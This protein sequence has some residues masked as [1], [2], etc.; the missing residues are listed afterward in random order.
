MADELDI[1]KSILQ[2]TTGAVA[3]IGVKTVEAGFATLKKL[4]PD[5]VQVFNDKFKEVTSSIEDDQWLHM[6]SSFKSSGMVSDSNLNNLYKLRKLGHPFDWFFYFM[7]MYGLVRNYLSVTLEGNMAIESQAINKDIRPYLPSY[8]DVINAAF[9]AP[10]KTGEVRD[11]LQRIGFKDEHIDLLFLSRYNLYSEE[12]VKTLYLQGIIDEDR[13]FIRMRELGYTDTRIKE[14]IQSWEVIPGPQDLFWMVGKEAFEPDSIKELG[15]GDEFPEEQLQWLSKQG[16]SEYW[17]KKYWYAHWDQPSIGQGYEMLHRGVINDDQLDMLF[18]TVEMPPFWR[19]KLKQ[20]A[21]QPFTRVDVR[22]MHKLG[23]LSDEELIKAYT[24]LGYEKEKAIKMAQFTIVYNAQVSSGL[25]KT[26]ILSSYKDG[27]LKRTDAKDLLITI[28]IG[29]D[30][31]EFLLYHID[32]KNDQ[33]LIEKQIKNIGDK[34]KLNLI[35]ELEVRRQLGLLNLLSER[36]DVLI[37][38]WTI[39][40]YDD[41]KIPSKTDLDKFFRYGIIDEDTYQQELKRLGYTVQSVQ[42]YLSL[43]KKTMKG[44]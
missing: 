8:S 44:E 29:E 3:P 36:V 19:E 2:I 34:F 30:E 27:M 32:Y 41:T 28:E 6:L 17:A 1:V 42:W 15:L 14:I 25:T 20:I 26:Q 21:Y 10:E 9:I 11:I 4:F 35:N 5:L 39:D 24:D 38:T 7:I 13:M 23:V 43:S 33:A 31:A 40:K 22:R 16:V 37:E 18:R 12:T